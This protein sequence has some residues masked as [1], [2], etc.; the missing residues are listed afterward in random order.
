MFP[1]SQGAFYQA[2]N[3]RNAQLS[4]ISP[5][6]IYIDYKQRRQAAFQLEPELSF[7]EFLLS[8]L[9]IF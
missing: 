3:Y 1:L 4:G 5:T 9:S 7:K 8:L 2:K 6:S